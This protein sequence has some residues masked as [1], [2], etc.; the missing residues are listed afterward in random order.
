MTRFAASAVLA[1]VTMTTPLSAQPEYCR[2]PTVR[3]SARVAAA[4][5]A[6][7]GNVALFAYFKHVWWSG[8]KAEGGFRFENDWDQEFRDQDKLGHA[9]GGYHLA[10]FGRDLLIASC[11]SRD[12][13]A[14]LAA[15]YATAFQLQIEIWDGT[16]AKYGF[17]TGDLL[18]NA[19][20]AGYFIGQHFNPALT[21]LKPTISYWPTDA[22]D[23]CRRDATK[24]GELRGT[25][26]YAGQTYWI[27]AD[28]ERLLPPSLKRAW[29]GILRLSLGH[30]VTDWIVVEGSAGCP[31]GSVQCVRR[32]RRKFVLSLDLDAEKLPGNH[33][34]WRRIKHDL[35]YYRLPAPALVL[36]PDLRFEGWYK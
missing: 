34:L 14:W 18:F 22:M 2:N 1:V 9:Y 10:R 21:A 19:L 17:S 16:Q 11:V 31:L 26:D 5:G 3:R 30:S 12:R 25:L 13:A 23:A 33:P 4:T 32:A 28:V 36:T 20:G 6:V 24:C 8:E 29:P 7:A 15:A 35:S 27:S